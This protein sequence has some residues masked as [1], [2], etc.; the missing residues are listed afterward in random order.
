MTVRTNETPSSKQ[1]PHGHN[2]L[3][4]IQRT[5]MRVKSPLQNEQERI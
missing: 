2:T 4:R 1:V 3:D 5:A